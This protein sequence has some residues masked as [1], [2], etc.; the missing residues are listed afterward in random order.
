MV[1]DTGN[2]GGSR[3]EWYCAYTALLENPVDVG[4]HLHMSMCAVDED[5][6]DVSAARTKNLLDVDEQNSCGKGF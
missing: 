1:L 5:D 3:R 2:R 6:P 4:T